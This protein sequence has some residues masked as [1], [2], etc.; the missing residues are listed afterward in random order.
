M[1]KPAAP[2]PEALQVIRSHKILTHDQFFQILALR[3]YDVTN[4]E[5]VEKEKESAPTVAAHCAACTALV[6]F[7]QIAACTDCP[8]KLCSEHV[9]ICYG[10][11]YPFCAD[12]INQLSSS[13]FLCSNC[14][15]LPPL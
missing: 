15:H 11:G 10:C 5:V 3:G 7:E 12:H 9:Y 14:E 8:A 1:P 2:I 13:L 4:L 6:T